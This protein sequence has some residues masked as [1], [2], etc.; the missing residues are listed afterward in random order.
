MTGLLDQLWLGF[1]VALTL[2][3]GTVKGDPLALT[4][5][6]D[7]DVPSKPF[8]DSS[9]YSFSPDSSRLVFSARIK[10]KSEPWST[11]FDLYEV[12]IEGGEP[13]NLTADNP[14]WDT[15]PIFSRDGSM[16]AW[17]AMER[18]GFE[19]DRF[20]IVVQDLKTGEKRALTQGWDRSVD[21]MEF[22]ADGKTIYAATD[23][24][25][26]HPLFAIDVKTGKVLY[27]VE[28][29]VRSTSH[30]MHAR[31]LVNRNPAQSP[32]TYAPGHDAWL[33][34]MPPARY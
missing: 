13:R 3:N 16:L 11:N 1:S 31:P 9:E 17:R 34:A 29:E 15:Q 19:A 6:L 12:S 14:A 18:P 30:P 22:S 28:H 32:M 33:P 25:G 8:G 20:H 26:Q 2:E 23:N 10:G 4:S 24:F 21:A 5:S 27:T 7:A